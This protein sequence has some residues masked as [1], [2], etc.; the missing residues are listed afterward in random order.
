MQK[1]IE[2]V[3]LKKKKKVRISAKDH[4]HAHTQ[5]HARPKTI[6]AFVSLRR[7]PEGLQSR[8]VASLPQ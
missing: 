7:E 8:A 5:R 3:H 1:K 6:E 4:T 2:E